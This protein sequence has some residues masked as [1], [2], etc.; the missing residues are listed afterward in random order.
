MPDKNAVLGVLKQNSC[1]F[2][3]IKTVSRDR[4]E[5]FYVGAGAVTQTVWNYIFGNELTYGIDDIDIVYFNN[6]DLSESAEDVVIK[7]LLHKL[8][9][10]PFRLDIK[11]QA[12]VHVW[13]KSKFG[14]DMVPLTSVQDAIDKWPTT[15]NSIGLRI[16]RLNNM[17]LYA[18]FG[19]DDLFSGIVRPNK[20]QI[21]PEIYYGKV[22]KWIK[23]WPDLKIIEW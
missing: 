16:N 4:T 3:I 6:N 1:L 5:K 17:E 23:K 11:N 12:R 20:S 2:D 18:P 22:H 7:T 14:Y 13:Y 21:T 19:L 15:A 8:K 9:H 10:V